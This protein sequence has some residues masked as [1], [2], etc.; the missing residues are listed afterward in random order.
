M[1][2]QTISSCE[3]ERS[4]NAIYIS[5]GRRER[6]NL[7]DFFHPMVNIKTIP[8]V[9]VHR[10]SQFTVSIWVAP[11]EHFHECVIKFSSLWK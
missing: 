10:E 1:A 4:F 8:H 2:T 9:Q 11:D 3:V 6:K 7:I 5:T